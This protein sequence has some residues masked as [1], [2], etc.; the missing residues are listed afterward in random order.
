M[1][2]SIPESV[3]ALLRPSAASLEPY[4][5]AF[6]PS[7][8][9]L[10]AN[11]NTYGLPKDVHRKLVDALASVPTNRY[12]DPMSGELREAIAAWHGVAPE[13]VC[14]G[15]GG[16]ELLFNLFLA[17]GG[18]GHVMVN[19]PPTF[20]VYRL[21]AEL[22]ETQVKD[23]P[24][25]PETFEVDMGALLEAARTANLVVVTSPNNP[26]GNLL[27][28][29][30]A[31]RLCEACPGVVLLD[32][33]YMEF[34]SAEDTAE[35]LL[36]RYD[37]LVV[38]HTFSKAFC[39]AGC[40]VGYVL[41][42]PGVIGALAAVRQPYS[43]SVLDQTAAQVLAQERDALASTIA[44]IRSE[45]ERLSSGLAAL[46]GVTVWPSAANF[47]LVRLPDAHQVRC[48]LRDEY[49][50]L[51]RDFSQAPGLRDCLRITVGTPEENDAVIAAVSQILERS[52]A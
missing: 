42:S 11:E 34:A 45:R 31:A 10:S 36:A 1:A 26:T 37:N 5:P 21:Y 27:S 48:T 9:N 13:Q 23:V 46:D 30:D 6:T 41:S 47:L 7:R 17:F 2:Q 18:S 35:P 43:V 28:V 15:N 20:S 29:E 50:I 49:S 52:R 4:D 33:A 25:D 32:E 8:I 12:P 39:L 38:L 16:D 3:R 44:T 40:R 51:V 24:R 19:V 22:V 14:V